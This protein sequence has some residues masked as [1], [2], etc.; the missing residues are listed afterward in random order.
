MLTRVLFLDLSIF[1][2]WNPE[3]RMKNLLFLLESHPS[4]RIGYISILQSDVFTE[5]PERGLYLWVV[6]FPQ[7]VGII[8]DNAEYVKPQFQRPPPGTMPESDLSQVP[9]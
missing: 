6:Y 4:L 7:I 9:I 5:L 1:L 3:V 8:Q 2:N